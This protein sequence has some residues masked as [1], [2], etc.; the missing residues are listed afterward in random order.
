MELYERIN[1]ILKNKKLTKKEFAK[2]LVSLEPKSSRTGEPISEKVV[3]RYLTGETVINPRFIPYI[4]EVLDITE[5]ELFD[6]T[7]K[8]RKKCFKYFLQNASKD[9]LEY[10]NNFINLQITNG[11]NIN[12]GSVVLHNSNTKNEHTKMDKFISLL[13]YA[14]NSFINKVLNRLEEYKKL[15]I[16][17]I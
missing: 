16:K 11:V 7:S 4:A 17:D 15:T 12:Y 9:E 2:R 6:T 5:Q 10:F 8:T 14:P 13:E 1:L 3:Y